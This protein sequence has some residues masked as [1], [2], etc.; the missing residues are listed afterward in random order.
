MRHEIR[1]Y[2]WHSE[3]QVE[4]G[5]YPLVT[6][7]DGELTAEDIWKNGRFIDRIWTCDKCGHTYSEAQLTRLLEEN[8]SNDYLAGSWAR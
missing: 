2:F 8:E 7:C 1:E 4:D 6:P 5:R 3:I